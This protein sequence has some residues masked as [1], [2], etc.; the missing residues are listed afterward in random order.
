LAG[1]QPSTAA[2]LTIVAGV[3]EAGCTIS[4]TFVE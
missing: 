1:V 3:A 4:V 2:A